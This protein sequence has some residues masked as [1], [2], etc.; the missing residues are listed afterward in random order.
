M[1]SHWPERWRKDGTGPSRTCRIQEE[2]LYRSVRQ[3]GDGRYNRSAAFEAT[4]E[5]SALT[6]KT[7][8]ELG[9]KSLP[10]YPS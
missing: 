4:H 10:P 9:G 3:V 8:G 5:R 1:D 6:P 7:C 2:L